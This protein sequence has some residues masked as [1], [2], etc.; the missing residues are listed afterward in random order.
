MIV[1]RE[2]MNFERGGDPKSAMGIDIRFTIKT[3]LDEMGIGHYT[4]KDDLTI[5]VDGSVYLTYKSLYKIPDFIQFNKVL[6][7]FSCQCNKLVSLR[8]VP[9]E[10]EGSFYCNHNLLLSLKDAPKKVG[11]A[12]YCNNNANKFTEKEVREV[13]DIRGFC[14][15]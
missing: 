12:F 1:K 15:I 7:D 10:I 9:K 8:G 4:I 5:D 13:C 2:N 14:R 6:G 11:D 3:W